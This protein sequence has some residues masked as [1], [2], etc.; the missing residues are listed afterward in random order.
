MDSRV[1]ERSRQG[2]QQQ[3]AEKENPEPALGTED[4]PPDNRA[5]RNRRRYQNLSRDIR[6]QRDRRGPQSDQNGG[7]RLLEAYRRL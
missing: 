4:R 7:Q 1:P 3:R 5:N 2:W 6:S